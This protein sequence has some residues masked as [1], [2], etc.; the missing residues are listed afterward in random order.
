MS[1][2]GGG[3][4]RRWWSW[5][6]AAVV[7]MSGCGGGGRHCMC[8]GWVDTIIVTWLEDRFACQS[9]NACELLL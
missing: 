9:A 8:G 4:S 6:V 5:V 7:V 3:W 2:G 1:G